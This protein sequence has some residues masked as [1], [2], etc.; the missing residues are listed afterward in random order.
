MSSTAIA[1]TNPLNDLLQIVYL[2]RYYR[3]YNTDSAFFQ[4]IGKPKT[5]SVAQGE[6]ISFTADIGM[7]AGYSW[8]GNSRTPPPSSVSE[9]ERHEHTYKTMLSAVQFDPLYLDQS[10]SEVAS[11]DHP[12]RRTMKNSL[13]AYSHGMNFDV[14]GGDGT[15]LLASMHATPA[16]TA[17]TF[18]VA[19]VRGLRHGM[20]IDVVL[21]ANGSL[22][23]S[24]VS[25][26]RISVKQSDG[27]LTLLTDDG[28]VY[29]LGDGGTDLNA[30]PSLYG[31]YRHRSYNNALS[32]LSKIIS[33]TGTYGGINRALDI[34]DF[35]R[36]QR[37]HN[38][39]TPRRP[40][41]KLFQQMEDEIRYKSDGRLRM[42]LVHPTVWNV[43]IEDEDARKRHIHDGK[44]MLYGWAEAINFHG[45]PIVK[46]HHCDPTKAWGLDTEHW[47]LYQ[48]KAAHWIKSPEGRMWE[49]IP[50][51]TFYHAIY[52]H[53]LE[54]VC[55]S[56]AAQCVLEDLADVA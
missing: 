43:L 31:V 6:K 11:A 55:H 33:Q 2:K 42:V 7:G 48:N 52:A 25:G 15:G 1:G 46:D 10:A 34:N 19:S 38:S 51:S 47:G 21:K 13:L 23:S 44:A 39:A 35:W 29:Q 40:K 16:A 36:S 37:L 45:I 22:G 14:V 3:Q 28:V 18:K 26:A 32:S 49:R 41:W 9:A 27:T 12:L 50:N 4:S 17:T 24:G 53:Q 56:P 30:N 5:E 8:V 20:R 54:V